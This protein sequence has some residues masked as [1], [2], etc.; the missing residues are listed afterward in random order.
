MLWLPLLFASALGQPLD[1]FNPGGDIRIRV[2][3][4]E[5]AR[6]NGT[7]DGRELQASDLQVSREPKIIRVRPARDDVPVNFDFEVPFNLMFRAETKAGKISV[8]GLV[9]VAHL[10]TEQGAIEVAAPWRA[11]RFFLES[12]KDPEFRAPAGLKFSRQSTG[13]KKEEPLFRITDR[14]PEMHVTHGMV[15]ING[16]PQSVTLTEIPYPMEAPVKMHWQAP[17]ILDDLVATGKPSRRNAGPAQPAAESSVEAGET[18]VFRSDVRVVTLNV[19]VTDKTGAPLT[20]LKA[21]D[22]E[23]LE[24][25][26]SQEVRMAAPDEVAFNLALFL[27]LSG[28]TKRNRDAMKESVKGFIDIARERDKFA[29]YALANDS[30]V[31]ISKLTQDRNQLL[32]ALDQIPDVSGSSP[33]YDTLV[34]AYAEELRDLPNERNA[35]IVVTDGEDNQINGVGVESLVSFRKLRQA[36]EGMQALIYPIY[37]DRFDKVGAPRFARRAK[38]N[39]E[40]LA[41]ASGGRVFTARSITDLAPVYPQVAE[42][43]RSVYSLNY[44]P[45]NQAFD[46]QW[47]KITVKVKDPGAKARTRAGYFAR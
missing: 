15:R 26:V 42:E 40:E 29:L 1:I 18:A 30:F 7:V 45:R 22:F 28:S 37:L 46:G 16:T 36:A 35:L 23:I 10:K 8:E 9:R 12:P 4:T 33:L 21:E 27:D 41:Q 6:I 3:S 31:V 5:Q 17:P 2:T 14:L 38:E 19:S 44:T 39:L 43:L 47:R 13:G 34:L 11:T 20:G 25:G 32:P 24:D